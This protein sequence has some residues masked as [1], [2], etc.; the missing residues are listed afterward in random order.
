MEHG[1]SDFA[2]QL[3]GA[4]DESK[5]GLRRYLLS[6]QIH[7]KCITFIRNDHN[8]AHAIAHCTTFYKNDILIFTSSKTLHLH[9]RQ[10]VLHSPINIVQLA[11]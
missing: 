6:P 1:N 7:H 11:A 8:P 4:D 3:V 5:Q 2:E 9:R 10:D